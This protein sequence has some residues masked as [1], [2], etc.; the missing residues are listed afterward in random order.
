MHLE[1]EIASSYVWISQL[2]I[3]KKTWN[4]S[5]NFNNYVKLFVSPSQATRIWE[6]FSKA[7]AK[8]ISFA[9]SV[10]LDV[11][12]SIQFLTWESFACAGPRLCFQSRWF[13]SCH[14][15]RTR[16]RC[17]CSLNMLQHMG[18]WFLYDETPVVGERGYPRPREVPPLKKNHTCFLKSDHQ[19]HDFSTTFHKHIQ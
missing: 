15:F 8:P 3:C 10:Y 12:I 19:T 5:W 14:M 6:N 16:G 4:L 1:S 13:L 9:I 7:S 17:L 18:F 11:N 2:L